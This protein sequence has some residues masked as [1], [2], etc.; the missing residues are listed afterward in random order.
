MIKSVKKAIDIL[1][2]FSRVEP[3]LSLSSISEK[4][5]FPKATTYHLLTTLVS[6]G[7]IEKDEQDLYFLGTRVI[8]I[9]QNAKVNVELRD[10]AAPFIRELGDFCNE[11]IY[12]ATRYGN[13]IFYIYAIETSRRLL[14]R[15]VVGMQAMMHCTGIGKA[16][17]A[18]LSE[19]EIDR[20]ISKAGL[21]GF[22]ESTITERAKLIDELREIRVN[23]Y[24]IDNEEHEENT[25]CIG[26]PIFNNAG[27]VIASCSVSGTDK[28]IINSRKKIIL[29]QLITTA[30]RISRFMGYVPARSQIISLTSD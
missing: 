22:T 19:E 2:L 15:S 29:P 17:L 25:F 10:Q 23:G 13:A 24:A 4:L 8:E 5:G 1:E 14:S 27:K 26:A 20:I 6:C 18:F 16:F 11:S 28:E 7:Y 21:P 9:S 3:R 30:M 12:L